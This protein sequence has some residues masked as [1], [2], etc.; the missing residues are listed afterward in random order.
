MTEIKLKPCPFCGSETEIIIEHPYFD[1]KKTVYKMQC[2]T[3]M[4]YC[5]LY[6]AELLEYDTLEEAA[7]AWNRRAENDR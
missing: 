5:L 3:H 7:E 4:P 1:S 6:A 2:Y